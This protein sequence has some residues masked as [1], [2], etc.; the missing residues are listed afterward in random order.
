[1]LGFLTK[2]LTIFGP[3]LCVSSHI[4][5]KMALGGRVRRQG[6]ENAVSQNAIFMKVV[7]TAL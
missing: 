1:M 7:N 6:Y 2:V 5:R 3:G 4:T